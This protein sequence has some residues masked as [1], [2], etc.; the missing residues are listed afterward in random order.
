MVAFTVVLARVLRSG[1]HVRC[2]CFGAVS[3]R[4]V[5]PRDLWRN[6]ALLVLALVAYLAG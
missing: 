5:S 3:S 1:L 2:A 6:G 4:D